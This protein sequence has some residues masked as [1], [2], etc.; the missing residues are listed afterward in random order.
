MG[1]SPQSLSGDRSSRVPPKA[2]VQVSLIA[3]TLR[4]ERQT[5]EAGKATQVPSVDAERR[6]P[7]TAKFPRVP[8]ITSVR[9]MRWDKINP[10]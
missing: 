10:S 9:D 2:Y 6:Y 8:A 5:S 7:Q 4:T 3:R 1:K